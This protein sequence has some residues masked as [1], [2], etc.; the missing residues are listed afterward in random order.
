MTHFAHYDKSMVALKL[1][2]GGA[3]ARARKGRCEGRQTFG[4]YLGE[5][6]ALERIQAL[7]NEGSG[8]EP[9]ILLNGQHNGPGYVAAIGE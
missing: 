2:G 7:R 8:F 1:A 5:A 6:A 4:Y 9:S 3:R